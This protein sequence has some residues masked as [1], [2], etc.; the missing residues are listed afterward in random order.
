MA[1][2]TMW[3]S[4]SLCESLDEF[5]GSFFLLSQSKRGHE[6]IFFAV[7]V[8]DIGWVGTS[9]IEFINRTIEIGR[10]PQAPLPFN[11]QGGARS[12]FTKYYQLLIVT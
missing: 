11:Y 5:Y 9:L 12:G 3:E 2:F 7:H 4:H 10:P 6:E 8:R 1:R